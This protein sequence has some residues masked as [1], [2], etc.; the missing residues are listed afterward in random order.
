VQ[1]N[2]LSSA[3]LQKISNWN[4]QVFIREGIHKMWDFALKKCWT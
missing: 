2:I 3:K 1:S 4:P